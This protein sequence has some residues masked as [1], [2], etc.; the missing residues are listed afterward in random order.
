MTLPVGGVN[1]AMFEAPAH[2]DNGG[3][4]DL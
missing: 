3:Y 2:A 4:Q 1:R